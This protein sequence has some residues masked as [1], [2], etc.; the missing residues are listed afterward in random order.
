MILSNAYVQVNSVDLSA[1]VS[2]VELNFEVEMQDDTVMGDE[3]RSNA[4]GLKNATA[5]VTFKNPFAAGGP[6]ATLFPL[7]GAAPF[8]VNIRPE[9]DTIAATNPEY[10]L[11][12]AL[13]R[14]NP[15]SG[16]VGDE[17]AVPA[18]FVNGT[19]AAVTRDTTP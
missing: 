8:S 14:W 4:P 19:G 11:T 15:L 13:S 17:N 16:N 7:L 9:N 6:D 18:E 2:Q 12:M 3:S 10:Q 5:T 1:Y